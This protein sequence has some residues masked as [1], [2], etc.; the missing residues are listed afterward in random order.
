MTYKEMLKQEKWASKR[1]EILERDSHKCLNCE[2][3][4]SLQVH[5]KV[6]ITGRLPWEYSNSQLITL[7]DSCHSTLH[8]KIPKHLLNVFTRDLKNKH[9]IPT[10]NPCVK[11][12]LSKEENEIFK[13]IQDHIIFL[14]STVI[15]DTSQLSDLLGVKLGRVNT[16]L[17]SLA[18][19]GVIYKKK[20]NLYDVN[21]LHF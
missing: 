17:K 12:E 7:C 4:F 3:N 18:N 21:I 15:L 6:Y 11:L 20:S 16:L 5:H 9:G 19:R 1:R 2:S 10:V 13:Y 14:S 8:E